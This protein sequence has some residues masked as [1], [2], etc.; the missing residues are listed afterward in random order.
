MDEWTTCIEQQIQKT[1]HMSD[2]I[3]VRSPSPT[4]ILLLPEGNDMQT[5]M[6]E[7]ALS[8]NRMRSL[9]VLTERYRLIMVY[10]YYVYS[11]ILGFICNNYA[12]WSLQVN[13]LIDILKDVLEMHG[14]KE[15]TG[16]QLTQV[17]EGNSKELIE[18]CAAFLMLN[19]W[20][21][22]DMDINALQCASCLRQVPLWLCLPTPTPETQNACQMFAKCLPT[23]YSTQSVHSSVNSLSR[24]LESNVKE[25]DP[26]ASHWFWCPWRKMLQRSDPDQRVEAFLQVESTNIYD[27]ENLAYVDII[28]SV[29]AYMILAVKL[30]ADFKRGRLVRGRQSLEVFPSLIDE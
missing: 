7:A 22:D 13:E 29:D 15:R 10:Y 8:F 23:L 1:A 11:I 6:R 2:C 30:D 19:G 21:M 24:K 14:F 4:N 26:I 5:Y 9:P 12:F 17:I 3:W 20:T 27:D 16:L 28:P 25:L 18:Q